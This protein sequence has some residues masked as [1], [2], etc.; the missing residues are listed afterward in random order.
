[1][2]KNT[3]SQKLTVFA[4][5]S[6]TNAPKTGD[7][8]N[9]TAY[10][11]KDD[12][13]LTV[14]ADTTATEVDST[15]GKGYYLFD[16]AQAETNADKLLFSA[17]SSTS[18]IVVIGVPAV[19]YTLPA[20][21]TATAITS[22]GIV[23]ADL[24]TIKTQTVTCSG[25]VTVPAATL[26]STTNITAGTITTVTTTTTAT[27][28]TTVNGLASGVITATSIAA[29]AITSAKI[30]TDAI[31]AAQL[32][33]DAVSEIQSG[34]S[35]LTAA[36][37]W[38]L[39]TSGHTTS[40]TFGAA[41]VAAGGAGDPW[42][43]SLPGSYGSGTAG[44]IVG[45]NLNATV[46]SRSTFDPSATGVKLTSAG[47]DLVVIESG[48]N[49]RQAVSLIASATAGVV[50]GNDTNSPVFKGINTNTTRIA[51]TTTTAGNRTAVT[52]SPPA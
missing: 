20:N 7:A 23:Q 50:G 46:S 29:N 27:N 42:S 25:G 19:V 26:A 47:L 31:G 51:A 32:A 11:S 40:G 9:I 34:L 14:L 37:V 2:F 36:G 49:A 3:A 1:M 44:Y 4:F 18:N 48:I 21:F 12:G 6:T 13:T 22:G 16:L 45:T 30:A 17:K 28:V 24:Q 5:D 8:S 43:T 41:A 10:V 35:T 15:N 39:A 38:D 52:L 33:A